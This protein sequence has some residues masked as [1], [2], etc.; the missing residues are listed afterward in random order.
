MKSFSPAG[1]ATKA[2]YG[3]GARTFGNPDGARRGGGAYAAGGA[4]ING[5]N[6]GGGG[7]PPAGAWTFSTS[8]AA[9]AVDGNGFNPSM[10]AFGAGRFVAAASPT[11]ITSADGG[12]NWATVPA[13]PIYNSIVFGNGLF[14]MSGTVT[15]GTSILNYSTSP[16]GLAWTARTVNLDV[17]FGI[18][19]NHVGNPAVSLN[20][21]N[22]R[23]YIFF[24]SDN[25]GASNQV[26]SSADGL[27]WNDP[28]A[29]IVFV[30]PTQNTLDMTRGAGVFVIA[31]GADIWTGATMPTLV[32]QTVMAGNANRNAVAFGAGLFISIDDFSSLLQTS[33]D[34]VTWVPAVVPGNAGPTPM[35]IQFLQGKFYLSVIGATEQFFSSPDGSTWTEE[36]AP[37]PPEPTGAALIL[38]SSGTALVGLDPF[39]SPMTVIYQ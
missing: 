21:V 32:R 1:A 22:G 27:N 38:G 8:A 24:R 6:Q 20:F 18:G 7:S 15:F 33:V 14:L 37:S 34:G 29:G 2:Y 19:F 5:P 11:A 25:L 36:I 26:I 13:A 35:S 28:T 23:F 9:L 12:V 10:I 30:P 16:D 39:Q 17:V 31:I 4:N 3:L